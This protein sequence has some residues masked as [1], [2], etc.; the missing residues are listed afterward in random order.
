MINLPI[1][2][3]CCALGVLSSVL[4]STCALICLVRRTNRA[5]SEK[6]KKLVEYLVEAQESGVSLFP[7]LVEFLNKKSKYLPK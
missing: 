6:E 3:I 2:L 5:T 1:W 7:K 4:L